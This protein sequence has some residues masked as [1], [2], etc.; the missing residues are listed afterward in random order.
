VLIAAVM[1]Y[2]APLAITNLALEEAMH[3]ALMP[4]LILALGGSFAINAI[5][6]KSLHST[7]PE[8]RALLQKYES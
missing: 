5:S 1:G 7:P 3:K 4:S 8:P 2:N 6:G